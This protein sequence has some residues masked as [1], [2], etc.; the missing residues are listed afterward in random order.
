MLL[1]NKNAIIYGAA[2]SIGGA[3]AKAF[4]SEGATVFL[5]GRTART[6]DDLAG[7]IH[8]A[9][10]KAKAAVVDALDETAVDEHAAAVAAEVGSVDISMN[11][12]THGDVQG[13]PMAQ[14]SVADYVRPVETAVRTQFI[15]TRAAARHMSAQRGGVILMFGGSGDPI[16]GYSIGGVQ[17]A[18]HAMEA[19]RRQLSAELGS[20]GIRV[21]TLRTGGIVESI[22]ADV[23]GR[24]P[25][26]AGI[27]E[28]TMLGRAASLVD[29]A[30]AACFAASD[31]ASCVTAAAINISAGALTD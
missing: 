7:E 24:D 12:I 6:L 27:D 25:I 1:N 4:A 16:R 20:Q 10:G 26:V 3:V 13:T 11:V 23:P 29:V 5:T 2:G 31:R 17:T 15:T 19:M 28:A 8:A 14:M 22:P 30:N 9:G 18:F 21:V